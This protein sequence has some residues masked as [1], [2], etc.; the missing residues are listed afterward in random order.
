MTDPGCNVRHF[1]QTEDIDDEG[2]RR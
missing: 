2:A 1:E